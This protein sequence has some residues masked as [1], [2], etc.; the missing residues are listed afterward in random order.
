M[1]FLGDCVRQYRL[2]RLSD[3]LVNLATDLT[4][5]YPLRAYDAV[6]LAT[7]ITVNRSLIAHSLPPLTFVSADDGLIRAAQSEGLT[8]D[9]PNWHP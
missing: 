4:Q 9:N 1:V 8:V 6:Q 5:Q 7:A 2:T 3:T